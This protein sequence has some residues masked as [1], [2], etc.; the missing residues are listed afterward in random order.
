MSVF[1]SISCHCTKIMWLQVYSQSTDIPVVLNSEIF[2]FLCICVSVYINVHCTF[3]PLQLILH[4]I[5]QVCLKVPSPKFL[6]STNLLW[7]SLPMEDCCDSRG[8]SGFRN[9]LSLVSLSCSVG[10]DL[11]FTALQFCDSASL[12]P[13]ANA[14]WV[15]V[16]KQIFSWSICITTTKQKDCQK[17]YRT[18][19]L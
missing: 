13:G 12:P 14:V 18:T 7:L 4:R 11:I 19:T 16:I 1:L 5:I 3:L 8:P 15:S 6:T 10:S 17:V 2:L 9:S